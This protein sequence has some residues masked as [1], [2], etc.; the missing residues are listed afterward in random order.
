MAW[1]LFHKTLAIANCKL[2]LAE[3]HLQFCKFLFHKGLALASLANCTLVDLQNCNWK[4]QFVSHSTSLSFIKVPLSCN[5]AILL[6]IFSVSG[7]RL[8]KCSCN[9]RN[10]LEIDERD[11]KTD[12]YVS[13][14]NFIEFGFCCQKLDGLVCTSGP[15]CITINYP[16][17][18][19]VRYAFLQNIL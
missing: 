10:H 5:F 19:R 13:I 2:Q 7:K 6:V 17:R 14:K 9:F 3:L 1:G 18:G 8:T 12:R 4:S 11:E 15:P 16:K